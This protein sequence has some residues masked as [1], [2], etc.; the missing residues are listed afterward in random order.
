MQKRTSFELSPPSGG[1]DSLL[2]HVIVVNS[3]EIASTKTYIAVNVN[4]AL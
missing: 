4:V 2:I 3:I 1:F